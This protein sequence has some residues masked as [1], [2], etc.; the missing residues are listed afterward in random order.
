MRICEFCLQ[1]RDDGVCAYGLRLPKQM[2]CREF[3]PGMEKFC[4][5][6][7]DFV[8]SAQIIQMATFFGIRGAELKKIK[9]MS[10]H[11]EN[12]IASDDKRSTYDG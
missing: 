7:A 12:A 1:F 3:D 11:Q 8:S 6:P 5:N 2:H 10:P 9:L 4:S